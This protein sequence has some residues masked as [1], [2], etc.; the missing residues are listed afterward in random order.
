MGMD[1]R[2]NG[3]KIKQPKKPG[4]SHYN[5]TKSGRLASGK[6][7]MDLVAKKKKLFLEYEVISGADVEQI[8]GLIDTDQM[9]FTVSYIENGKQRSFTGYVGEINRTLHRGGGNNGWYWTDAS[10]NIIEQ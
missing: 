7:T 8:L 2:I 3:V 4:L 1:I 9:F 5:L 10:F 6:M